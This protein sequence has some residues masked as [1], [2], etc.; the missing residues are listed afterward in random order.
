MQK[1][2]SRL[3]PVM[4][5]DLTNLSESSSSSSSFVLARFSL[6]VADK[7]ASLSVRNW[8]IVLEYECSSL[9]VQS[10]GDRG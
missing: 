7:N 3:P 1:Q 5:R 4:A 10:R 6:F 9:W 2:H 8:R